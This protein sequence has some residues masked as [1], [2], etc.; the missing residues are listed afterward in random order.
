MEIKWENLIKRTS[1]GMVIYNGSAIRAGGG[2]GQFVTLL[3][4]VGGKLWENV[5]M[6]DPLFD[7]LL[8]SP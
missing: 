3:I 6:E 2:F 4:N 1:L 5:N 7:N 8:L